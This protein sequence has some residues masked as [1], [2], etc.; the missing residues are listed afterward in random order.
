ME[1]G[2]GEK[3][4]IGMWLRVREGFPKEEGSS[5][6]GLRQVSMTQLQGEEGGDVSLSIP[7]DSGDR[8]FGAGAY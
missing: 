7:V 2:H 3:G 5:E 8:G 6:Q 1:C 4:A